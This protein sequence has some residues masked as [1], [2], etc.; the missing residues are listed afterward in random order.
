MRNL[1]AASVCKDRADAVY[2]SLDR[3]SLRARALREHV[4]KRWIVGLLLRTGQETSTYGR[5]MTVLAA[6]ARARGPGQT[7][8]DEGEAERLNTYQKAK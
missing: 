1:A 8:D 7:P 2:F 3:F 5:I 4:G 6:L